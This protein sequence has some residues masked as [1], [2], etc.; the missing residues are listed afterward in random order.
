MNPASSNQWA[1]SSNRSRDYNKGAWDFAKS[2]QP[3]REWFT[4]NRPIGL[5][6]ATADWLTYFSNTMLVNKIA[7]L[8]VRCLKGQVVPSRTVSSLTGFAYLCHMDL[9]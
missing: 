1:R 2:Y 8:P 5:E 6:T 3:I 9:V 4:Q 7:S